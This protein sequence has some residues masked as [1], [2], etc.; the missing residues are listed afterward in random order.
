MQTQYDNLITFC[1]C[2]KDSSPV[3]QPINLSVLPDKDVT[4][5]FYYI[6]LNK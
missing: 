3:E 1:K 4:G 2:N 6:E 5:V